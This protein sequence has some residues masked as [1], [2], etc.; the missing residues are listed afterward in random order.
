MTRNDIL[1]ALGALLACA[2]PPADAAPRP[3]DEALGGTYSLPADF[4]SFQIT[5]LDN[6]DDGYLFL[7]R[8]GGG[9]PYT[10]ILDNTGF[11]VF[12]RSTS[13][14]ARDFKMQPS[15]VLTYYERST[16]F[17]G[18][19]A[20]DSTYTVTDEWLP[21]GGWGELD[22]HDIQL[23]PNG[24]ALLFYY[25][26]RP[27]DMSVVVPGGHPAAIVTGLVVQEVD[28]AKNVVFEWESWDHFEITDATTL[29]LTAPS[30][31]YVHCNAVELDTDGN[32]LIS[33]RHLDEITKI[34]RATGDIVWRMGG[35][36]NEFTL[37]GDTQ[38]YTR[39]HSVR[40]T[41]AGTLTVF[42][43]GNLSTPQESRVVEYQL[44]EVNKVATFVWEFRNT[45]AEYAAFTGSGQRLPNGNTLISWG[46]LG[47]VTE[48]RPDGSKA[49]E[50]NFTT[51]GE[52]TYRAFR[53]PW[54]GVAA[55]PYVWAAAEP[56][57]VTLDFAKFGDPDVARF[58]VYRDASPNPTTLV[59][60]T[61]ANFFVLDDVMPSDTL[62]VRITAEDSLAVES[63][64]SNELRIVVPPSLV[65]V[66]LVGDS[67]GGLTLHQN[68]PN[69]FLPSTSIR[70]VLPASAPAELSVYSV[71]GRLVR[72]L[73]HGDAVRGI[74]DVVWD[75]RDA[76]GRP[77][78]AGVYF[79]RLQA[80]GQ[81]VT[82]K[83]TVLR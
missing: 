61:A 11:P 59:G 22:S 42:D 8:E 40:R 54:D 69:P 1:V 4:P 57:S 53:F 6:P 81:S 67:D 16:D 39:Q 46:P 55:A 10:M 36:R 37:V 66:A 5:T 19:R 60:S 83:M 70:F 9:T 77:V 21:Q 50:M 27:V 38:W 76:V 41:D 24:H 12:F 79:Y 75:G 2:V 82:R 14:L 48:V 62:Y 35:S 71:T 25:D 51:P 68:R 47:I 80:A 52:R 7:A 20:L 18:Y 64:F 33:S 65:S 43:N 32:I 30:I 34:D 31:D 56:D 58:H 72:T 26:E 15:G 74:H 73:A 17:S 13:G 29:D 44:D 63:P 28:A 49:F 23:L 45:P 78:A 3:A